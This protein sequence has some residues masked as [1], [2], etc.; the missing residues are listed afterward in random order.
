[1]IKNRRIWFS[2]FTLMVIST[3]LYGKLQGG[4]ISWF[5]FYSLITLFIY[6]WAIVRFSLLDIK[7][8]R[9]FIK[10]H[11]SAG[12]DIEVEIE[13]WNR[14]SFPHSYIFII[15]D[16]PIKLKDSVVQPK[17]IIYP[18]FRS[19]SILRYTIPN[20]KRGIH[21][22]NNMTLV[23]GDIF[24]F[25]NI[26]KNITIHD[27]VIVYPHRYPIYYWESKNEQNIG[28]TYS[29]NKISQETNSV[30]GIREYQQGDRFNRI[31]WK[32]SARAM[33]L[34][35]KEF[36]RQI[37]NDFMFFLDR[38]Q[39]AYQNVS[40]ENFEVGI[41]IVASLVKY[42]VEKHFH[43]GFVSS[44]KNREVISLARGHEQVKRIYDLLALAE[45][46]GELPFSQTV[47]KEIP[48]LPS[49]VTMV[50]VT[51]RLDQEIYQ[52]LAEL[53]IRRKKVEIYY[54][55]LENRLLSDELTEY[56]N[57]IQSKGVTIK[58][59]MLRNWVKEFEG[60]VIN[61]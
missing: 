47:L 48:F 9:S 33:Q 12:E 7:V 38:D 45:V 54:I 2:F 6:E 27:E 30:I 37:T 51:P 19:K 26:K 15:D 16:L 57:N 56:F 52:L 61:G 58:T 39:T 31:H 42:A 13:F 40:M 23:T 41:E 50:L 32:Q 35:S 36:E 20:A 34:M 17:M 43:V 44:G 55:N 8:K 24:G 3:F 59:I 28:M 29:E 49:G 25:S 11:L 1:M 21:H 10:S 22:W 53:I 14:N 60:G 18:W 46:D 4:F 5:L